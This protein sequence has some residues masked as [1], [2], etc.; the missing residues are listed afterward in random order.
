MH[1]QGLGEFKMTKQ[2]Q[3]SMALIG[4]I[5]GG[6]FLVAFVALMVVGSYAFSPA[7]FL[8][9]VVAAAV[10]VFLLFAFHRKPEAP[11]RA[12]VQRRTVAP[13]P[14][15]APAPVVPEPAPVMAAPE[16]AAPAGPQ[17]KPATLDA[18]RGGQADDLKK[19]KGV[20]P[21]MEAMLHG[22]GFYH[23]DQVAN[24]SS[25]EVAWVDENLEGFKGRVSRDGWVE[26]AK[27]LAA[28]GETEFSRRA[29]GGNVS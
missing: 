15:P 22:M 10:A 1:S 20:G 12:P 13:E 9:A 28:G 2:T 18:P 26:Q 5:A 7:L 8:A 21:K 3:G 27:I 23:F 25:A 4:M 16:P 19:I 17:V 29:E 14:A 24:W 6:V 11:A